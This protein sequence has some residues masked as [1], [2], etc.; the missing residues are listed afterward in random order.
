MKIKIM[1]IAIILNIVGVYSTVNAQDDIKESLFKEVSARLEKAR[2]ENVNLMSPSF[3]G[4]ALA[5]YNGAEKDFKDGSGLNEIKEQ[6]IEVNSYLDKAFK[7]AEVGKV[8]FADAIS[9]RADAIEVSSDL[10]VPELWQKAVAKLKE[11]GEDLEDGDVNDARDEAKEAEDL[12]RAAEL[13]AIKIAYLVE[14]R[15]KIRDAEDKDIADNAPKT[16]ALAKKLVKDTERELNDNRYDTDLP[17]SLAQQAQ[18]EISHAFYLDKA[19][20]NFNDK[21]ETLENLML[22]SESELGKIAGL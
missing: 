6:I 5:N 7:T 4:E 11:A 1:I 2:S 18:Y 19:I 12:F 20:N 14:T 13:E 10:N 15:N 21:D 3:Y 17:R 8:T 22:A 9:A 16:L